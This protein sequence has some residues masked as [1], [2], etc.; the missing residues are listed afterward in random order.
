MKTSQNKVQQTAIKKLKT[1]VSKAI[2]EIVNDNAFKIANYNEFA[3][4]ERVG[5]LQFLQRN[6]NLVNGMNG[7]GMIKN[8]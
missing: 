3:P 7:H 4:H 1:K 5:I 8:F 2:I 6:R